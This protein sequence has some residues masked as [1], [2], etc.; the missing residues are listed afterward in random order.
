M[1]TSTLALDAALEQWPLVKPFR[2]TGFVWTSIEVLRVT[3]K[4][5]GKTGRGE[6]AGVY[7]RNDK[8]AS[9]L[10]QIENLRDRIEQGLTRADLQRV[11]P[12]GGA[13]NALDCALWDLEAKLSGRAAWEIAGIQNPRPLLTTFTCGAEAPEKMAATARS[14][15]FA[16]AIKLKLTGE[17][18]DADR[19][20]AVRNARPDV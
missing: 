13:R 14:Y 5:N 7:Y 4:K 8:P 3:L 2:I 16:R 17:E 6:A 18:P 12:P 15:K 11:L 9:M 10:R 1:N 20:R 19:I